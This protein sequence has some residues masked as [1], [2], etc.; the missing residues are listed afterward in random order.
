[1]CRG[2]L[3]AA[4]SILLSFSGTRPV[5]ALEITGPQKVR[6]DVSL[7]VPSEFSARIPKSITLSTTGEGAFTVSVSGKLSS[8][9]EVSVETDSSFQMTSEGKDPITVTVVQPKSTWTSGDASSGTERS[10]TLK[11]AGQTSGIWE[12]S[13]AFTV[14]FHEHS[15]T[16]G[17]CTQCGAG[18]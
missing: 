17:I 18:E 11:A 15:Y 4:L 1:M 2:I 10:S 6:S 3:A 8:N 14:T 7:S 12:G 9:A 13:M 5:S 16:G